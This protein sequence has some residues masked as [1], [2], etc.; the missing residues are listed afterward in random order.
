MS[1]FKLRW[2][3]KR[4]RVVGE[5][6]EAVRE[7]MWDCASLLL[8]STTLTS[9]SS[10][11]VLKLGWNSIIFKLNQG[12]L[13]LGAGRPLPCPR[14][15]H[16]RNTEPSDFSNLPPTPSECPTPTVLAASSWVTL[17]PWVANQGLS[18]PQNLE[19]RSWK[20]LAGLAAHS[21][22]H[23]GANRASEKS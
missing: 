22:V 1:L 17:T 10:R 8:F 18:R 14:P 5:S 16:E 23:P 19:S 7:T 9:P 20:S 11:A 13:D 12:G 6:V 15:K 3:R 2:R 4:G 21:H